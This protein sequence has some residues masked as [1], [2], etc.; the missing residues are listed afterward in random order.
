VSHGGQY[1]GEQWHGA[2]GIT[3]DRGQLLGATG[4][5][6]AVGERVHQLAREPG[7]APRVLRR[8]EHGQQ[9][10]VGA[11]AAPSRGLYS[12]RL[13]EGDCEQRADQVDTGPP[14]VT[15]LDQARI[16]VDIPWSLG[17]EDRVK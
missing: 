10:L 4:I 5:G 13:A 2:D 9:Q 11:Y 7:T 17:R 14:R 6:A 15:R 8:T 16:D 3:S 12:H 1:G